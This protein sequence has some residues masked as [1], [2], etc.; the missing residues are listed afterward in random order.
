MRFWIFGIIFIVAVAGAFSR[1]QTPHTARKVVAKAPP[2][3][4]DLLL[5]SLLTSI[6]SKKALTLSEDM[7]A[8]LTDNDANSE[9]K[10]SKGQ[11]SLVNAERHMYRIDTPGAEG[12]YAVV[13][14]PDAEGC[15][16]AAGASNYVDLRRSWFSVRMDP[17]DLQDPP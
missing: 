1:W 15:I 7:N 10:V 4:E 3:W 13:S 9:T 16:L 2:G 11:W 12:T 17:T 8:E 5:C 6:D 14:P